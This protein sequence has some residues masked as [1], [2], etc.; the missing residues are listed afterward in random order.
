MSRKKKRNGKKK[1]FK[2]RNL[3]MSDLQLESRRPQSILG[4]K[5]IP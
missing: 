4:K 5:A 2:K 3:R 1:K